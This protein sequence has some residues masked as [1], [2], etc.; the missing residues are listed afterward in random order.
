[1]A[2]ATGNQD[3]VRTIHLDSDVSWTRKS[4][5]RAPDVRVRLYPISS[6]TG[7]MKEPLRPML[8]HSH[9]RQ[10]VPEP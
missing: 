4:V 8:G 3:A 2:D 5:C 9:L 10:E 6:T 7:S 1:M